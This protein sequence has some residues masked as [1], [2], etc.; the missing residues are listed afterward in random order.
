MDFLSKMALDPPTS[1]RFFDVW[2][3][4][5]FATF[6]RGYIS[7]AG[8]FGGRFTS[9]AIT[10]TT[11]R[12]YCLNYYDI[13]GLSPERKDCH[14]QSQKTDIPSRHEITISRKI[15]EAESVQKLFGENCLLDLSTTIFEKLFFQHEHHFLNSFLQTCAILMILVSNHTF[16]PWLSKIRNREF[17][18]YIYS[19]AS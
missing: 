5:N 16:L 2:I 14:C 10:F 17:R 1:K 9:P 6:L 13:S 8:K 18:L 11:G 7:P 12:F 3:F 15:T 19:T 4:F